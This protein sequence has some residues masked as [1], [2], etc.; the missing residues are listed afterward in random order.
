MHWDDRVQPLSEDELRALDRASF[1]I[2]GAISR[3]VMQTLD[4]LEVMETMAHDENTPKIFRNQAEGL[5]AYNAQWL[6]ETFEALDALPEI[7]RG[8]LDDHK[9]RYKEWRDA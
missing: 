1:Y 8:R 4:S 9:A 7:I 6:R 2:R 5:V 3:G